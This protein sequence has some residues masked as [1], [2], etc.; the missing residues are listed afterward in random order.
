[1]LSSTFVKVLNFDK[2]LSG[3]SSRNFSFSIVRILCGVEGIL[4][5]ILSKFKTLTKCTKYSKDS[6]SEAEGETNSR[7]LDIKKALLFRLV[8]SSTFVKVLN[9]DKGLSGGSSR[10]FSFSLVR[11]LCGVEGILLYTLSKFKTLTKCT[12][13]SKDSGSE[14]E[15]KVNSLLLH[16]KKSVPLSTIA[17]F[18]LCQSFE[19]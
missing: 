9:F 15:G 8:L 6:R 11:I 17:L 2:G 3:D 7:L 16:I 4:L 14:A 10:N 18:Y 13:D 12:K 19:L 1:V 5:Y